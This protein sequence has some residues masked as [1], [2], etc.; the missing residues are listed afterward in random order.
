MIRQEDQYPENTCA[1]AGNPG[2]HG[3]PASRKL[4]IVER[5]G[6]FSDEWI[7]YCSKAGV[8]FET[9]NPYRSDLVSK[10][11]DGAAFLWHWR[12][13]SYKAQLFARQLFS[14]LASTSIRT[15]PDIQT[16]WHFDDKVAQKYVFEVAGLPAAKSHVF[17]DQASA[18]A[19]LQTCSYPVVFK[20]RGGAGALNVRLARTRAEARKLVRKAFGTGFPYF[21]RWEIFKQSIWRARRDRSPRSMAAVFYHLGR[22]LLPSIRDESD[23]HPREIGYAYFQEFI[24]DNRFDDRL[25][26]VGD[27]CFA[28]RRFCRTGDF[29]ASGSGLKSYEPDAFPKASIELAFRLADT[30]KMQSVAI[31]LVYTANGEPMV[32]EISFGCVTSVY[33]G[34]FDR[35]GAWH[36]GETSMPVKILEGLIASVGLPPK[37]M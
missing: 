19:W 25:V 29:R 21:E 22:S 9:V 35:S 14:A 24:P 13:D 12:H 20:L 27:F 6:S 3:A 10:I 4:Y 36:D 2:A 33:P 32:V 15:Y 18:D 5:K 34:Y 8:D 28:V 26:V 11:R 23:L 7:E 17:Y 37:S 31:D 1:V 30:L 16:C